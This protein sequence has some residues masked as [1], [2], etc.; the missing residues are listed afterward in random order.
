[1]AAKAKAK[2]K[3]PGSG[4]VTGKKPKKTKKQY[5]VIAV[6]L[7]TAE[8]EQNIIDKQLH[9]V[10][11]LRNAIV[12]SA[13]QLAEN[14]KADPVWK[15]TG[16]LPQGKE[17]NKA[18]RE[19]FK[20][21]KLTTFDVYELGL[22]HWRASKWMSDR[23]GSRIV[24]ALAVEI[25]QNVNEWVYARAELPRSTWPGSRRMVWNNDNKSGLLYKSDTG[26]VVWSISSKSKNLDL[27]LDWSGVSNQR[28]T[29][30]QHKKI[31]RVGIKKEFIRG[32]ERYFALFC[33][34]GKPYRNKDYLAQ[35]TNELQ[36]LDLGPGVFG[37]C[38]EQ[39]GE[40]LPLLTPEA[41]QERT[42]AQK[43]KRHLQRKQQRSRRANN[44]QAFNQDG[45]SIKG[46]R[47]H[48]KSKRGQKTTQSLQKLSRNESIHRQREQQDLIRYLLTTGGNR[49]ATEDLDYR[50]WQRSYG[51]TTGFT[52][53]GEFMT[54]LEAECLIT[55]GSFHKLNHWVL[56]LS[57]YCL[58]GSKVKK[59]RSCKVH[60]CENCGLGK[61]A[62]LDREIFSAFLARLR[63]ELG[64][65]EAFF[66]FLESDTDDKTFSKTLSGKSKQG[67]RAQAELLCTVQFPRVIPL[68][69]QDLQQ[70]TSVTV[71]NPLQDSGD[72]NS[73]L[74]ASS[75]SLSGTFQKSSIKTAHEP[76][77]SRV[78]AMS[79][80]RV[81]DTNY[82][83]AD[84]TMAGRKRRSTK[85]SE[86]VNNQS[87]DF[88]MT[89]YPAAAG[90]F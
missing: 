27:E 33:I 22:E 83:E 61:D 19:L 64:S 54:R 7:I 32:R 65:D 60:V 81:R 9:I 4:S 12:R 86:D 79:S 55:N 40:V 29:W 3:K 43:Q 51:S 38:T 70:E 88:S 41:K 85:A 80:Y 53:P 52:A 20:Q 50:A 21:Y 28:R 84:C 73:C 39:D 10:G 72:S 48:K 11:Q 59:E 23:I 45:T 71:V 44:P 46:V 74:K 89:P 68:M 8:R 56:A 24:N 26:R 82:P 77:C 57:Q 35:V 66:E 49:I 58:C 25:S 15:T 69:R 6:P 47:Q 36:A 16:R 62:P 30:L 78:N 14:M 90:H 63:T 76:A 13:N 34:E 37:Q 5:H 87:K 18:Y 17:K 75:G 42:K 1:M 2:P 67:I 31:I